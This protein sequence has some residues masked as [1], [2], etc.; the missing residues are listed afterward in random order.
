MGNNHVDQGE[1]TPGPYTPGLLRSIENYYFERSLKQLA[2]GHNVAAF[3]DASGAFTI[4][5]VRCMVW[6]SL[7]HE[8][9]RELIKVFVPSSSKIFMT[10][11]IILSK[12]LSTANRGLFALEAYFCIQECKDPCHYK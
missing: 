11:A 12:G 8:I 1:E 10:P 3:I 9:G 4:C 7:K 6:P 5:F 2:E